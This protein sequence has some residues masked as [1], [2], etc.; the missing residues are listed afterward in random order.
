MYHVFL[1][2]VAEG[3]GAGKTPIQISEIYVRYEY[4]NR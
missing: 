2:Q 3:A 4:K 1:F